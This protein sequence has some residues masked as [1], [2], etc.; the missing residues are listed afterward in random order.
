MANCQLIEDV[1]IVIGHIDN[2]KSGFD[3]KLHNLLRDHPRLIY[4]I[5]THQ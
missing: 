4:L 5:G 2:Y 3:Q 1:W